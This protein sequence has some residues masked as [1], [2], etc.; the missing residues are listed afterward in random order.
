MTNIIQF[1]RQN[2]AS[3]PIEPKVA[4]P[5]LKPE[6][7]GM[8][9]AL[10]KGIWVFTVLVWPLLKWIISIDCLFHLVRMMYYWNT[11]GMHAGWTFIV[12]FA[13]LTALTYFVSAYKPRRI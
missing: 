4:A 11:P 8:G 3:I 9:A 2:K 6:K 1:P 13:V 12:H 10:V 5:V 7:P